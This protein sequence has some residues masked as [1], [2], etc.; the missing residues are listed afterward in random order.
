MDRQKMEVVFLIDSLGTDKIF[1]QRKRPVSY[2][3]EYTAG[4]TAL[5]SAGDTCFI[6]GSLCWYL[7]WI[8]KSENNRFELYFT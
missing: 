7:F 2:S 3:T 6:I 1:Y 8:S 5:I 4:L